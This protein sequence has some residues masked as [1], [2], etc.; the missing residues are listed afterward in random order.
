MKTNIRK[1][2][3]CIIVITMMAQ[4][5]V[6][7]PVMVSA[8]TDLTEGGTASSSGGNNPGEEPAKAFDNSVDTKWNTS[9]SLPLTLVYDFAGITAYAA[10]R[11]M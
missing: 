6:F 9:G 7:A 10:N 8:A 5:L 1:F 2:W 11:Y 3:V 4:I